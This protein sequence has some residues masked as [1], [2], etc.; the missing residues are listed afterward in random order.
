MARRRAG[1]RY[2]RSPSL[3]GYWRR[4]A[5][6]LRA[7]SSDR[8]RAATRDIV[9]LLEALSRWT[10]PR[11]LAARRPSL[12]SAGAVAALLDEMAR[13]GWLEVDRSSGWEESPWAAWHPEASFFHFA[14]TNGAYPD[15][16]LANEPGYRARARTSPAPPPTLSRA[17][18]RV[19]LPAP[20][21]VGPIDDALDR[22]QTWR[23]FSTKPLEAAA[24]ATVLGRTFGVQAWGRVAGQGRVVL[25]TSPSAGARHPIE[26]YVVVLNVAGVRPGAYHFDAVK[27]DLTE[28]RSPLDAADVEASLAHQHYFAGA[29]A[30]VVMTAVVARN[31]WRYPFSR[32]YRTL[33]LDAGHLGQTFCLV[34]TALG[35]AP[36]CTMA[37]GEREIE[38]LLSLD[39][40]RDAPLYVVG[41]GVAPGGRPAPRGVVPPRPRGRR[42]R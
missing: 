42:R 32:A 9:D 23:Q 15:D 40:L 25:K 6:L 16:P 12:G 1:R 2:R 39:P 35:L 27:G 31:V 26:A 41:V 36:F 30:I 38:T 33:L 17:G 22:R 8:P 29:A 37:F 3:V 5:Y 19:P 18:R 28:I 24:L 21:P 11:Q 14:T 10:T 34:A 7:W 4:G 13:Y 20:Q